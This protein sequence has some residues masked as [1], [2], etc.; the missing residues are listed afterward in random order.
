MPGGRGY[1][2]EFCV[3]GQRHLF[4]APRARLDDRHEESLRDLFAASHPIQAGKRVGIPVDQPNAPSLSRSDRMGMA[5]HSRSEDPLFLQIFH[6][7]FDD[8][9]DCLLR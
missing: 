7:H 3:E 1:L 8:V 6:H 4:P 2:G 5:E 9:I